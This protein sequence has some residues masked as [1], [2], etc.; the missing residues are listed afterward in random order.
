VQHDLATTLERLAAQGAPGFYAG[1][2][3]AK[4]VEGVRAA[5][6]LWTL[7]DLAGYRVREREPVQL[8]YRGLRITAA[9]LPSSGGIVL[10]ETL[11]LLTGFD[12]TRLSAS[13]RARTVVEALRLAYRDRAEYLGDPDFVMVDT[14]RLLSAEYAAERRREMRL[15]GRL[16]PNAPAVQ[17]REN[18]T[19]FSV[20]DREGNRAAVTL[21]LNGPFGAVFV[22]PGTGVLLNNEMD[23]FVA[24]PGV[25][26][27]YGLVG[28]AANAIAPGKRPLSSMTPTFVET[29]DALLV[30]GTPGGSRIIS[31]VLL[32]VLD[33]AAGERDVTRLVTRPRF[34]HQ[35]LPDQVEY[36]PGAWSP[37]V[38]ASLRASGYRLVERTGGYGNMQA[39]LWDK[40]KGRL[41][42]ASDP[43]GQGDARV[44]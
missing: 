20:I 23:D 34:H 19:H 15:H 8:G 10:G 40:R 27:L 44:R 36:E 9:A 41:T 7:A 25:P 22:P 12:L 31:M 28:S 24:K 32:A 11:A 17:E 5:G 39:I 21:S 14:R 35:Y 2:V 1:P 29:D 3:A 42:A 26:N 43:R 6:G 38:L 4:L 18:T 16:E 37:E 30:L 13:G 33:F